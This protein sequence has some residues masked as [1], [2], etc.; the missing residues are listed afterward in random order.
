MR[1]VRRWVS[2]WEAA[3]LGA[4]WSTGQVAGR[5]AWAFE[6][7]CEHSIQISTPLG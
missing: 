1:W 6:R 7:V 3:G 2:C 4:G 5:G